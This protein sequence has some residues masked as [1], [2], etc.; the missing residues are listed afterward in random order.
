MAFSQLFGELD[1]PGPNPYGKP[2]LPEH[3]K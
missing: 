3:P 2:F 1:P